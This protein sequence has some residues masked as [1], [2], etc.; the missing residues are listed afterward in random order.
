MRLKNRQSDDSQQTNKSCQQLFSPVD[1]VFFSP[2]H[3]S[4]FPGIPHVFML[5]LA[6][7]WDVILTSF[8]QNFV[9]YY[10]GY[11]IK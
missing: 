2:D 5:T 11:K 9:R 6:L 1:S 3:E 8:R 10:E 4:H 7:H